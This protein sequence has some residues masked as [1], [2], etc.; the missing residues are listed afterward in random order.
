[1]KKKRMQKKR[2]H[3]QKIILSSFRATSALFFVSN[4]KQKYEKVLD[5]IEKKSFLHILLL[6]DTRTAFISRFY[7]NRTI[8]L[9]RSMTRSLRMFVYFFVLFLSLLRCLQLVDKHSKPTE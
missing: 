9:N 1:M 2:N 4:L 7:F 5:C 3:T 8:A 6:Y